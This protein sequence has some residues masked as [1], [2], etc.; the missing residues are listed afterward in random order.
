MIQKIIECGKC[1]ADVIFDLEGVN[2]FSPNDICPA[3]DIFEEIMGYSNQGRL[4]GMLEDFYK[5]MPNRKRVSFSQKCPKCGTIHIIYI[6][7]PLA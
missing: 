1:G 7:A 2:I 6:Y 4:K 5:D 3:D